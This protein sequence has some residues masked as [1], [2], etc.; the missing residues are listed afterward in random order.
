MTTQH[1]HLN[2]ATEAAGLSVPDISTDL[3]SRLKDPSLLHSAG[4]IG[5][6]WVGAHSTATYEVRR[7]AARH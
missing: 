5:G 3:L 2:A 6:K 7:R 1:T 4:F